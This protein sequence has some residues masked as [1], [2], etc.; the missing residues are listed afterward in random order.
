MLWPLLLVCL[1]TIPQLDNESFYHDEGASLFDA[2]GL[3]SGPISISG[4]LA[5]VEEHSPDQGLGWPVLLSF[6][7]Q[8]VGWS[9]PAIRTLPLLT[10]LLSIAL[11]Y[12][13][14]SEL[15]SPVTGLLAAF[16]LAGS[17]LMLVYLSVTRA[18]TMVTLCATLSLW[19]YWRVALRPSGPG[20]GSQAGLF[21][22]AL[23]LL[24][25]HFFGA[26]ILPAIALYH[27]FFVRVSPR[28]WRPV[29]L[30]AAALLLGLLQIPVLLQGLNFKLGNEPLRSN[31]QSAAELLGQVLHELANGL[32]RPGPVVS[33]AL[34][35]VLPLALFFTAWRRRRVTRL[36]ERLWLPVFT[37]FALL[38]LVLLV[39]WQL[40]A[41]APNRIRYLI[42][43][44]PLAAFSVA[45]LLRRRAQ[46]LP[47]PLLVLL[48]T[49]WTFAGIQ[50]SRSQDYRVYIHY[51]VPSEIH[52]AYRALDD[53]MQPGDLLVIDRE[54]TEMDPGR[55]YDRWISRPYRI[56]D[57]GLE[58]PL[59][60][61]LPLHERH[62]WVWLLFRSQDRMAVRM[63][64]DGLERKVCEIA[65][66]QHGFS[67]ERLALPGLSCPKLPV[68]FDF[69]E[70]VTLAEPEI[71]LQDGKLLVDLMLRSIDARKPVHFS[72]SLQLFEIDSRERVAQRDVGIGPGNVIPLHAGIDTGA[73]PPG[74]YALRLVLYNWE[75]GDR[76]IGRDLLLGHV[77]DFHTL[78][79]IV[80][81]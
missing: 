27:L 34:L 45:I 3:R 8:L 68:R 25:S 31:A 1:L 46:S 49:L 42:T 55:Y 17:A 52:Q 13:I 30:W 74:E 40:K 63:T 51:L 77:S 57:R 26:W 24:H 47:A 81:D 73:L 14:G 35:L 70:E 58:D 6:W 22:G 69:G 21:L 37:A 76:I 5:N 32:I 11:L 2:G 56:L 44:W 64:I 10:G 61:I 54:A 67:L 28:W 72:V 50:F 33:T 79:H 60:G 16:L 39:N 80:L 4:I 62:P 29:L 23:G 75:T 41:M 53:H 59:V 18:F 12:R 48:L 15:F 66:E 43:L 19:S 71:S 7:G 78:Q 65:F 38:W 9:E 20:A 36:E